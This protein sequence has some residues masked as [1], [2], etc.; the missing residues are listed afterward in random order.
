MQDCFVTL[1]LW[2]VRQSMFEFE[3]ILELGFHTDSLI[4]D[5]K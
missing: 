5:K 3:W 2:H 1:I 4:V